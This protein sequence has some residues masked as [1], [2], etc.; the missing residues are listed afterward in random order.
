MSLDD[1][2]AYKIAWASDN[3]AKE[4]NWKLEYKE[5][6]DQED[7]QVIY[8]SST[9]NWGKLWDI[10]QITSTDGTR[11]SLMCATI[12]LEMT[13]MPESAPSIF[14]CIDNIKMKI[15]GNKDVKLE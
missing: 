13:R 12:V 4:E 15:Y 3:K 6:P 1:P 9:D 7:E 2:T 5:Q 8:G 14:A 11:N 10:D